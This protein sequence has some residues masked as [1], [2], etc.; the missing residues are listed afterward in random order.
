L[1]A[2]SLSLVNTLPI[3]VFMPNVAL[4]ARNVRVVNAI[5]QEG[6]ETI[7]PE[8]IVRFAQFVPIVDDGELVPVLVVPLPAAF[9]HKVHFLTFD[10]AR[11]S[12]G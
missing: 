3:S 7:T 10:L 9:V 5:G 11:V 2:L 1:V 6:A 8:V 12:F 4:T